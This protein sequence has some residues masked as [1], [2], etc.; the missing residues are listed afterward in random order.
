MASRLI[1]LHHLQSLIRRGRLWVG[2]K[3]DGRAY[4]GH[5]SARSG[6]PKGTGDLG[7]V[8]ESSSSQGTRKAVR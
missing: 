2:W 4:P 7:I 6:A 8:P 5:R 3:A 1:F